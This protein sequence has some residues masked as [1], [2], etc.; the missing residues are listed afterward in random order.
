MYFLKVSFQNISKTWLFCGT[1]RECSYADAV[2][3]Y[4]TVVNTTSEDDSGEFDAA[5]DYPVY[6]LQA[7]MAQLYVVGGYGLEMDPSYAGVLTAFIFFLR[8]CVKI[9]VINSCHN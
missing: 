2:D 6:Q 7:A 3:W 9:A 1:D 5:M 4:E 8:V